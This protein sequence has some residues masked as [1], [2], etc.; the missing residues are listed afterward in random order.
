MTDKE[1]ELIIS[2]GEGYNTEFKRN[3]NKE[4]SKEICSFLNSSG[5]K[6][7][8]GVNDDNKVHGVKLTNSFR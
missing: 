8:I 3:L 7:L 1:F 5:G 6:I 4:I 2:Q